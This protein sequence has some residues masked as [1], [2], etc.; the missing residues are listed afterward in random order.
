MPGMRWTTL[1]RGI[2]LPIEASESGSPTVLILGHGAGSSMSHKTVLWLAFLAERA[3]LT[4][5]R[6]NFPYRVLG[7][8]MPDRM[9]ALTDAYREVVHSVRERLAP[10]R[11]LLGGHSMGGR[12]ASHVLAVS[13]N[14]A[15]GLVLFGY[16]LHPAGKPEK[17]R[18]DH[19][20]LIEVPTFQVN[21]TKDELC[22]ASL[23]EAALSDLDARRW[24]LHWVAEADHSYAVTKSSGRTKA[25]VE[26]E[27]ASTLGEWAQAFKPAP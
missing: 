21:G 26:D 3:G 15:N 10:D 1:A 5:V 16:P 25:Q 11:L 12:V 20:K 19:L 14:I 23:M 24:T 6:F 18:V 13:P 27:I 22:I 2:A 8:S 4:V 9:P 17:L 7:K